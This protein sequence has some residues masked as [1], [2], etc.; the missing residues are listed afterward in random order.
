MAWFKYVAYD[1]SGKKVEASIEADNMATAQRE[2]KEF[3]KLMV[4]SIVPAQTGGGGKGLFGGSQKVAGRDL[5]YLTSELNLLLESGVKFDQAV[6][7][8]AR[9]KKNTGIG[10]VLSQISAKLKSGSTISAAFGSF[11]A[12]FDKLYV[13]LLKIGEE[14]G[15]LGPV[16]KGL[17]RDLKFRNDLRQTIIQATTYPLIIFTVCMLSVVFIFNY[18]VPK[19]AVLFADAEEL[20]P[21]TQVIL[22]ISDWLIAWQLYIV[23]ALFAAAALL[24]QNRKDPRLIGWFHQRSR[25][26]PGVRIIVE[27]SE[28]IRFCSSMALLLKAGIAMDMAVK[29]SAGNSANSEIRRELEG[30]GEDIRKG[31]HLSQALATTSLFSDLFLSLI[32]IGEESG[33]VTRIFNELADRSRNEFTLWVSRVTALLEPLLIITMGLIVG[34]VVVIMMLSVMSINDV[35]V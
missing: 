7:L 19:M 25:L 24:Y 21:A 23:V 3:K 10:E 5:E 31:I 13:N 28:R 17:S 30:V 6:E 32:E 20:P 2:L 9:A 16:F 14:S 33:E 18:I 15:T 26:V 22:A 4:S 11:S 29:L 34:G 27:M 8:L 12:L 1:K 35:A